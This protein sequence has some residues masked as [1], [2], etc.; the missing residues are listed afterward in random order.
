[1]KYAEF[2]TAIVAVYGSYSKHPESEESLLEKITF[3]YIMERFKES[4]L[5]DV[6]KKLILTKSAKFKTPPDPAEFEEIFFK[7][8]NKATDAEA[9]VWW[10]ELNRKS[11]SWRNCII[12]DI[13]AQ[14]AIESMGGWIWFCQRIKMDEQGKDLDQWHRKQFVDLFKLYTE[15]PPD[16]SAR[17]LDGLSETVKPPVMIGNADQC[18]IIRQSSTGAAMQAIENMTKEMRITQ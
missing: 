10:E 7:K 15:N 5:E 14:S 8:S 12:S 13:R 6:F 11:N 4:E 9:L 1:M 17:V 18:L 16:R 3:K 2:M